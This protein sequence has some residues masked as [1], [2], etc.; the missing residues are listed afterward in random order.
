MSDSSFGKFII[1]LREK[2]AM[3]QRK[4][5]EKA[6][7]TNSTI[8]RLEADSVKPDNA[9]LDKLSKALEIDKS[10]LMTKC[11]YSEIPEEFVV[12]AR[13]AGDL[14]QEKI[15]EVYRIFNQTI[16]DF[17]RLADEDEDD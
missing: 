10:L 7:L 1:D 11:G 15:N 12:I 13:K 14:P 6:G 2:K 4:L 8:S 17:L 16:D 9:T 5:A 3:S